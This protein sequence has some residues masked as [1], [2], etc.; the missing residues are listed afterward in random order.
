MDRAV[1]YFGLAHLLLYT[2]M[3]MSYVVYNAFRV[4]PGIAKTLWEH[5]SDVLPRYEP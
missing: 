1:F 2:A 4:I 3:G 5:R